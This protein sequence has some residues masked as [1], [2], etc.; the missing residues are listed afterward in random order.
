MC[1][2]ATFY[3]A[4]RNDWTGSELVKQRDASKN[5]ASKDE[6]E[7]ELDWQTGHEQTV[8]GGA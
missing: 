3:V 7:S 8:I 6:G 5:G 4:V 2:V 1:K